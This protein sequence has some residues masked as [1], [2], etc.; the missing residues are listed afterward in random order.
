MVVLHLLAPASAGGLERV[1]HSL[2]LGQHGQGHH[3][4]VAAILDAETAE[5]PFFPP[6][7]RAGIPVHRLVIPPRAYRRER[8]AVAALVRKLAPDV[9]HSHGYRTDVADGAV[10]RGLGVAMVAT[11]H[12]FTAGSLKNRLYEY[13]QRRAFRRFDAVIAVSRP[14]RDLLVRSGVPAERVHWVPNA[15]TGIV[16]PADGPA[17]RA[18]LGLPTD[19][20]VVGWV[21]RISPEKGLD[22]LVDALPALSDLPLTACV[23]GAGGERAAVEARARRLGVGDRLR[24]T[25]LVPEAARYFKAFDVF[26][27]TSRTEGVPMALLEAVAAEVPVVATRVGGV[28]AV[29]TDREAMLVSPE[30]P[31]AVAAA[32]RRVHDDQP[33]TAVRVRA[34]K[35][36]LLAEFG[37]RAW[38]QRHEEIYRSARQGGTRAPGSG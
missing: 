38:L 12:G 36:R 22:V 23:I 24:W 13:L 15:W 10:I 1:V 7:E 20:F 37:P 21:G 18:A 31:L 28:P 32:I 8:A 14:L 6:L 30:D 33:A 27:L 25:G 2:A 4:E 11:A 26:A 9:V 19:G 16:E 35:Q 17:A 34:A 3:V 29:V 5:H